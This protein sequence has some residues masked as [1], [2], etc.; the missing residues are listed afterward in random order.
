M[1]GLKKK[2]LALS[3][4]KDCDELH[5]WIKSITNHLYWVAASTPTADGQL[6]TQK[7]ESLLNHIQNVHEGHGLLFPTCIHEDLSLHARPKKWLRP[8]KA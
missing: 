3:K 4:E 2:L 5:K 8:G 7:W 6:M 1:T